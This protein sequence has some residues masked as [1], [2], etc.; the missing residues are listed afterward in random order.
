[1]TNRS[2]QNQNG[3]KS[4]IDHIVTQTDAMHANKRTNE[5]NERTKRIRSE[6]IS[7]SEPAWFSNISSFLLFFRSN[8][9]R[10]F[11]THSFIMI[12]CCV[13]VFCF[14][15][16]CFMV[17]AVLRSYSFSTHAIDAHRPNRKEGARAIDRTIETKREIKRTT[18]SMRMYFFTFHCKHV[19]SYLVVEIIE[20]SILSFCLCLC[21][22]M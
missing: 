19:R 4:R 15:F 17:V 2:K 21:V 7:C 6:H 1:M 11:C 18:T 3:V 8:V 12:V 9:R 20:S 14:F 5:R 13:F 22:C 16:V 10:L